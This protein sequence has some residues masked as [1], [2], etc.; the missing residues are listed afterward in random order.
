MLSFLTGD[1]NIA[2][3]VDLLLLCSSCPRE[4]LCGVHGDFT[5]V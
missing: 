2:V 5:V 4:N 1:G 3:D